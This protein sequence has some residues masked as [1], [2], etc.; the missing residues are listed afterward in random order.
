MREKRTRPR[1]GRQIADARVP[2]LP[3]Q[4]CPPVRRTGPSIS[5]AGEPRP[6][7]GPDIADPRSSSR[8]VLGGQE[9]LFVDLCYTALSTPVPSPSPLMKGGRWLSRRVYS[10]LVETRAGSP[11]IGLT[12]ATTTTKTTT[13]TS[14]TCCASPPARYPHAAGLTARNPS[15]LSST[16]RAS[17]ARGSSADTC[18]HRM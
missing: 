5:P 18:L 3:C 9:L 2:A 17:C 10:R 7:D 12:A 16:N 1:R 11:S 14:N 15:R 6:Q 13:T 4:A 8:R